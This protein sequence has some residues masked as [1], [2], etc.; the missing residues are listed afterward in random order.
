MEFVL[1]L[2]VSQ[3]VFQLAVC[4]VLRP[5]LPGELWEG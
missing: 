1:T 4:I 3:M 2:T 5:P